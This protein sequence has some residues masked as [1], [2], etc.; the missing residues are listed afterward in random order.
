MAASQ[1]NY[2]RLDLIYSIENHQYL[3]YLKK[4]S[5]EALFLLQ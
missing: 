4:N 5:A 1:Q 3:L 2:F